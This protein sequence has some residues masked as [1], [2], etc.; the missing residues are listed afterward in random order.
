M[1]AAFGFHEQP[2]LVGLMLFI[3]LAFEPLNPLLSFAFSALSRRWE[4]QADAYAHSLGHSV[5]LQ[6][7]LIK[8]HLEN[9]GALAVDPLY[10]AYHY[11]HPPLPERLTALQRLDRKSA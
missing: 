4:Y 7:G 5:Q 6:T 2:V 9:L 8:L 1:F 11:S 10:S 3:T